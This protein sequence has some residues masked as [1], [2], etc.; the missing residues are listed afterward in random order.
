MQLLHFYNNKHAWLN[1]KGTE[2]Q[3]VKGA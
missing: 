3:L 2:A 1:I